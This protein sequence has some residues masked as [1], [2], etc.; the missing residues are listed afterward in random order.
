MVCKLDSCCRPAMSQLGPES[1]RACRYG[2]DGDE[3]TRTAMAAIQQEQAEQRKQ[4]KASK[5]AAFDEAYDE[6]AAAAAAAVWAWLGCPPEFCFV[7]TNMFTT[8]QRCTWLVA[9]MH[10]ARSVYA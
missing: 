6:G 5:K 4:S 1:P 10:A 7:R 2:A 9:P 3:V 8:P